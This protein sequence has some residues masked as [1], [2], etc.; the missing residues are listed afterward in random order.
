MGDALGISVSKP[1]Q[2]SGWEASQET[3]S[4]VVPRSHST[5]AEH[6]PA[7]S[8]VFMEYIGQPGELGV[9]YIV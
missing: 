3:V 5:G 9:I 8:A 2:E 4:Y 1:H 7:L 6:M